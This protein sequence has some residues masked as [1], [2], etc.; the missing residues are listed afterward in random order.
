MLTLVSAG[1]RVPPEKQRPHSNRT[2]TWGGA[3]RE[4]VQGSNIPLDAL[5][6]GN[7]R[8]EGPLH[9]PP[10]VLNTGI[11]NYQAAGWKAQEQCLERI[12]ALL[13]ESPTQQHL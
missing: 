8:P 12:D 9:R 4:H 2:K 7:C 3:L 1:T 5:R 11:R 10:R 13:W 6:A